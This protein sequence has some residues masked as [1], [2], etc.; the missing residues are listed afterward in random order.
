MKDES[1]WSVSR[2]NELTLSLM[3]WCLLQFYFPSSQALVTIILL[4]VSMNL[5]T[6]QISWKGI[7]KRCF[8]W[9]IY[10]TYCPVLTVHPC[11]SMWPDFLT[12]KGWITFHYMY[13][14][15]SA[16]PSSVPNIWATSTFW[17][18]WIMLLW[19]WVCKHVFETQLSIL[20]CLYSEVVLIDHIVILVLILKAFQTLSMVAAPFHIPTKDAQVLLCL[21][22]LANTCNLNLNFCI[23]AMTL[24]VKNPCDFDFTSE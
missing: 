5:T 12:L 14:P 11:C 23:I 3:T 1:Q 6:L 8:L 9:L 22:N 18:F 21:H 13:V 4:S 2:C 17:L 19:T 15:H 24:N 16:Y 7:T 20:L 10:C